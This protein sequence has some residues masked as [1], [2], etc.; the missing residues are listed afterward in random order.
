M[1]VV[2]KSY[3]Q[4]NESLVDVIKYENLD[5][6]KIEEIERVISVNITD[7][8]KWRTYIESEGFEATSYMIGDVYM[9]FEK[10]RNEN[11]G[12]IVLESLRKYLEKY[13]KQLDKIIKPKYVREEFF[14]KYS[15]IVEEVYYNRKGKTF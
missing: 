11:K 5:T 8:N 3:R 12:S 9:L 2:K 7:K 13:E 10:Y 14:D 6:K 1:V 15:D 4:R